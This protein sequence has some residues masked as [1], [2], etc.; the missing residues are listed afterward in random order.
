LAPGTKFFCNH[1][2]L[3]AEQ[4]EHYQRLA[5]SLVG[6]LLKVAETEDGCDFS[7]AYDVSTLS[8][9]SDLTQLEHA[10]CPFFEI[11]IRVDQQECLTWQLSGADGVKTFIRSEFAAWMHPNT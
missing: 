9:L 11:A 3:T 5:Q 6:K 2:A 1:T 8:E 4:R 7:F 10:C